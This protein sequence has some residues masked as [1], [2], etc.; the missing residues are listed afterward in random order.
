MTSPSS[1]EQAAHVRELVER[2]L[3]GKCS[4]DDFRTEFAAL[5]WG[6]NLPLVCS[7]EL[8]LAEYTSGHLDTDEMIKEIQKA[9]A[10]E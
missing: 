9:V 5:T 8:T 7:I 6:S 3:H 10:E 2:F 4:F 1:P